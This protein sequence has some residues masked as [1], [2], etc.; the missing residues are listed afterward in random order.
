MYKI[1]PD[2]IADFYSNKKIFKIKLPRLGIL[3]WV[4]NY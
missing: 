2:K 3:D 1:L 4:S